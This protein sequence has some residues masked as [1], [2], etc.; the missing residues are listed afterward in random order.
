M[1][2]PKNGDLKTFNGRKRIFYDGYWITYYSP[3]EDTLANHRTLIEHLTKRAFHHTEPGINT[4]GECL[5]KA[6]VAYESEVNPAR[7]RI[8]AAMLAGALFN[9][10]T[11]IFN[12]IV[13]LGEKGVEISPSNELMRQCGDCFREALELGRQV[14]HYSGEEGI[15][16]L[17]G[18]PLKAFTMTMEAFYEQRYCKIS[19][20]MRDID[21]VADKLVDCF[22]EL[23]PFQ[24]I[25]R[26]VR[27]FAEAAKRESETMK[28]DEANFSIWPNFVACAESFS[29]FNP[30]HHYS[31]QCAEEYLLIERGRKI[32]CDGQKL[33]SY[34][35]CARVPMPKSTQEF[36]CR[37]DDYKAEFLNTYPRLSQVG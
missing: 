33:I 8:N 21:R 15:D 17:W 13:S 22:H 35:A 37:L 20:T 19:Q 12:A 31:A 36:L 30:F 23:S 11:D 25:P 27:D 3:P 26:L 7:K 14:R 9:R 6:R 18:E 4:P 32:A 2:T 29:Q 16:E 34:V 10:A 24:G 5:E 1:E 28:S